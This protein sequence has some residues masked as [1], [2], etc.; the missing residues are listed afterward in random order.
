MVTCRAGKSH[1]L[2][3]KLS[4]GGLNEMVASM[5]PEMIAKLMGFAAQD[6][7][8]RSPQVRVVWRVMVLSSLVGNASR[9]LYGVHAK[10]VLEN[11]L[12]GVVAATKGCRTRRWQTGGGREK[13]AQADYHESQGLSSGSSGET[14][15][16]NAVFE[17]RLGC[18]KT[19]AGGAV[20]EF[21]K[22]DDFP[23]FDRS[24]SRH[25]RRVLQCCLHR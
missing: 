14:E 2:F 18:C 17:G 15:V 24:E 16:L 20:S 9:F 6:S 11:P 13:V 21:A 3:P 8:K 25:V 22:S 12:T 5:L 19:E 1:E 7:I 4:A 10:R 23:V